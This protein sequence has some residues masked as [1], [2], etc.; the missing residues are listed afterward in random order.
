M[1]LIKWIVRLY[2]KKKYVCPTLGSPLAFFV[3]TLKK[4]PAEGWSIAMLPFRIIF[5]L[6]V[7][8][9]GAAED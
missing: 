7:Q 1:F 3:K 2:R 5:N 6:R 9:G 8:I 4:H